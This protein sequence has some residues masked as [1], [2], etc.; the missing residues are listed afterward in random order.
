MTTAITNFF[1]SCENKIT[2]TFPAFVDFTQAV[3][4]TTKTTHKI[5]LGIIAAIALI[6]A[7]L[8]DLMVSL[9]ERV[10]EY[11]N[12]TPALVATENSNHTETAL[13]VN[14]EI[15]STENNELSLNEENESISNSQNELIDNSQNES[16]VNA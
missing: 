13:P 11:L 5:A 12:P 15:S 16:A 10:A 3:H 7:I 4:S 1:S 14:N 9:R 8:F 2:T 6:P